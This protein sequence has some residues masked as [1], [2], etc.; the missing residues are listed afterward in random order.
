MPWHA[1]LKAEF[2]NLKGKNIDL[3][4]DRKNIIGDLVGPFKMGDIVRRFKDSLNSQIA[5]IGN[6]PMRRK[7][8]S[9][10]VRRGKISPALFDMLES[11]RQEQVEKAKSYPAVVPV[12]NA[13]FDVAVGKR[14]EDA[15]NNALLE[16]LSDPEGMC[17]ASLYSEVDDVFGFREILWEQSDQLRGRIQPIVDSILQNTGAFGEEFFK[18]VKKG[19]ASQLKEIRFLAEIASILIDE[20]VGERDVL[21]LPGTSLFVRQIML[22]ARNKIETYGN[23]KSPDFGRPV[24][25]D[26]GDFADLTHTIYAPYVDLFCCDNATK[27]RLRHLGYTQAICVTESDIMR[28]IAV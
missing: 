2:E 9:H 14:T 23:P 24:K 18:E 25:I 20:Q 28:E 10:L 7:L 12:L 19:I 21:D 3:F 8:R 16:L 4:V 5:T 11:I 1:L 17:S 22:I 15:A 6:R 26:R 27:A 13:I